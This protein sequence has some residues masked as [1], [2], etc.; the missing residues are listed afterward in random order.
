MINFCPFLDPT[1][2][3][4]DREAQISSIILSFRDKLTV[5]RDLST[6]EFWLY[7]QTYP[8]THQENYELV[9]R[10]PHLR[11]MTHLFSEKVGLGDLHSIG[12]VVYG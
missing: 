12:G 4:I 5:I 7:L 9:A 11:C 2:E 10:G 3:C 6:Q 8:G 1:H